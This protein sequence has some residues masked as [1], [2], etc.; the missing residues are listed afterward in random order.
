MV[1][2]VKKDMGKIKLV[3]NRPVQIS[4]SEKYREFEFRIPTLED[5]EIALSSTEEESEE[6]RHMKQ[7][8]YLIS[9]QFSPKF[10][11]ND[12]PKY[13]K[14]EEL[15]AFSEVLTPFLS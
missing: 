3:F 4:E 1:Q 2:S 15:K 7:T 9:S 5:I 14:A 10:A 8:Y 11:P 6:L 12:V 13:M